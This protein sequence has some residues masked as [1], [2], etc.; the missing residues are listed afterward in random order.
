MPKPTTYALL[1]ETCLKKLGVKVK[2]EVYD[3]H[4]HVD[5]SIES[6]KLDI[7]VDGMHHLTDSSQIIK[8]FKRSNYSRDDGYETIHVHNMDLKEKEYVEDIAKA[9]AEVSEERE[10]DIS[11]MAGWK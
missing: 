4:K 5:L 1:L 7:E 6:G 2:E 11:I 9:I 10:E 3:G 8:D